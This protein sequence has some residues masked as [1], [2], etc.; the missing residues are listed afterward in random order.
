M[1]VLEVGK[2]VEC[3]DLNSFVKSL[4]V[5]PVSEPS[6]QVLWDVLNV[7]WSVPKGPQGGTKE[8]V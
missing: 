8:M 6:Q 3:K 4:I 2:I 1:G 7:Q 5:M